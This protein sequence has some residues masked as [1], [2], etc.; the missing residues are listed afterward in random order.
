MNNI[1]KNAIPNII[2]SNRPLDVK[3]FLNSA[4]I[5][6]EIAFMESYLLPGLSACGDNVEVIKGDYEPCDI[7]VILFSP[8]QGDCATLRFKRRIRYLHPTNLLICE[9][10]VLRGGEKLYTRFGFDHVHRLGR[11]S[12]CM[13]DRNRFEKIGRKIEPWRKDGRN[14]VIASQVQGD[15]SLDGIDIDEWVKCVVEYASANHG[16]PIVVRPHPL[17]L[18]FE[19]RHT[20]EKNIVISRNS[21]E[22]DIHQAAAWV[23]YTSGSSVDAVL[24]GV[25]SIALSRNNLAWDVSMHRMDCIGTFFAPDRTDWCNMIAHLQWD[26]DEILSGLAWSSLRSHIQ[27]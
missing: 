6:S 24:A 7:A 21:L 11:F 20:F 10:P 13:F 4:R 12:N 26:R 18:E 8:R 25:T 3:I 22:Y 2:G 1:L 17:D 15:Y 19:N 5:P 14:I 27:F 23:S 9:M 16:R